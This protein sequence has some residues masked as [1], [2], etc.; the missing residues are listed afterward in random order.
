[1]VKIFQLFAPGKMHL[2][3]KSLYFKVVV[4][5]AKQQNTVAQTPDQVVS[6]VV[7][8]GQRVGNEGALSA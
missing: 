5:V 7:S 3:V 4:A 6:I 8:D 1:V 2:T